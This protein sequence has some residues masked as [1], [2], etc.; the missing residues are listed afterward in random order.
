MKSPDTENK[1][2]RRY[3]QIPTGFFSSREDANLLGR[4]DLQ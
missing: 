2:A 3:R 1:E 4:V